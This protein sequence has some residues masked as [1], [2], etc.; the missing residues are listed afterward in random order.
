MEKVFCVYATIYTSRYYK[1]APQLFEYM[2]RI[3]GLHAKSPNSYIWRL[4]D[5]EFH[6]RKAADPSLDWHEV[7]DKCLRAVEEQHMVWLQ[8]K[9]N[10]SNVSGSN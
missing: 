7:N 4:Y 5:E 2:N 6:K 3:Y 1:A 10:F 9:Q 8:K